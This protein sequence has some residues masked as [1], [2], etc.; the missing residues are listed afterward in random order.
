MKKRKGIELPLHLLF[1]IIIAIIFIGIILWLVY[2][3]YWVMALEAKKSYQNLVDAIINTANNAE[4][5]TFESPYGMFLEDSKYNTEDGSP[6]LVNLPEEINSDRLSQ[7][8]SGAT[9]IFTGSEAGVN[10]P[11]FMIYFDTEENVDSFY[12]SSWMPLLMI[13]SVVPVESVVGKVAKPAAQVMKESRILEG[14]F[15]ELG[16]SSRYAGKFGRALRRA[17]GKIRELSSELFKKGFTKKAIEK[18]SKALQELDDEK[19][20]NFLDEAASELKRK[21]MKEEAKFIKNLRK[22]IEE[23]VYVNENFI[24]PAAT[25][26]DSVFKNLEKMPDWKLREK[27][28][29]TGLTPKNF[30][31]LIKNFPFDENNPI[32]YIRTENIKKKIYTMTVLKIPKTGKK[33]AIKVD[34]WSK[35]V[36]AFQKLEK[37]TRGAGGTLCAAGGGILGL[38]TYDAYS[39]IAN[40]SIPAEDLTPPQRVEEFAPLVALLGMSGSVI[41]TK[42]VDV[43]PTKEKVAFREVTLLEIPKG[44]ENNVMEWKVYIYK[45][46][47]KGGLKLKPDGKLDYE[48]HTVKEVLENPKHAAGTKRLCA[49]GFAITFSTAFLSKYL[50]YRAEYLENEKKLCSGVICFKKHGI[51]TPKVIK[52][53]EMVKALT[54]ANVREIRLVGIEF[55]KIKGKRK[56]EEIEVDGFS[57]IV[58][59]VDGG[60]EGDATSSFYIVSP[61][62]AHAVVWI[63]SCSNYAEKCTCSESG[64]CRTPAGREC[65]RCMYISLVKE[66]GLKFQNLARGYN[67]CAP[68]YVSKK[69]EETEMLAD[70]ATLAVCGAV[71]VFSGGIG[72][73]CFL[74]SG[75]YSASATESHYWPKGGY[76][77][78]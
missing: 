53:D 32:Y 4:R 67:Y 60:N 39:K 46:G 77:A 38:L 41:K 2:G 17:G 8:V 64:T 66:Y 12:W 1:E 43:S 9:K 37:L 16:K 21:G 54:N 14:V 13:T 20:K 75:L 27:I 65:E 56:G 15:K 34:E 69:R 58:G 50:D 19:V 62:F 78:E 7:I 63:G 28:R 11:S 6:V 70:I 24:K 61:C 26:A 59:D 71:T 22:G 35:S 55:N 52:R 31:T 25:D 68:G 51:S 10:E 49:Y 33:Y 40:D 45:A 44:M 42:I 76:W 74:A 18:E 3:K 73:V 5:Y 30:K 47:P 29:G 36:K 23:N 72:S 48:V 57:H